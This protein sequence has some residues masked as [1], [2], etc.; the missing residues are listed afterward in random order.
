M[1]HSHDVDEEIQECLRRIHGV[2]HVG[3]HIDPV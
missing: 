2:T 1:Q 3:V